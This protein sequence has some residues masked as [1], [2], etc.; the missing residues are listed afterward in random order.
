MLKVHEAFSE[1]AKGKP[2]TKL[3][4]SFEKS[5]KANFINEDG[6]L[7]DVVIPGSAPDRSHR[8]NQI[9]AVSLPYIVLS[10]ADQKKVTAFV[11]EHLLTDYG[12]RTL[13]IESPQFKPKYEG[14]SWSRDTAYHQGTVWPFLIGEF[15]T[16]YLRVNGNTQKAKKQV[17]AWMEPLREHFYSDVC[18]HGIS[19]IFDGLYPQHGKGTIHQAWSV[20][21][22]LK[23]LI[24][25]EG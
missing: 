2:Y 9:Y 12:L 21:A 6:Y 24:E 22:L 3:I 8:P 14:D 10:K 7:N 5:F 16:A 25:M 20:S 18:V 19:E 17:M 13:N 15:F 1:V 4:K 11:Q 23:V